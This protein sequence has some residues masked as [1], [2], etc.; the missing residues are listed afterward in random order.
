MRKAFKA[1]LLFG[2]LGLLTAPAWAVTPTDTPTATATPTD[3]PSVTPTYTATVGYINGIVVGP[4]QQSE[5]AVL[6]WNSNYRP[7][8]TQYFIYINGVLTYSPLASYVG[9]SSTTGNSDFMMAGIPPNAIPASITIT[10]S[11]HG[12]LLAASTPVTLN[13]NVPIGGGTVIYNESTN[14]I[15]DSFAPG[16]PGTE[17]TN[18]LYVIIVPTPT[19]TPTPP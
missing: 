16:A 5:G 13:S 2:L 7:T 4:Y 8:A 1:L 18:P 9:V 14:P 6:Y 12:Q 19:S 11:V 10:A 15:F 3:T 17:Y